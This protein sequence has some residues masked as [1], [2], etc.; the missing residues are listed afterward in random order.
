MRRTGGAGEL[1]SRSKSCSTTV[2]GRQSLAS[3]RWSSRWPAI[4]S[5]AADRSGAR[6]P[7]RA[8]D[9]PSSC[10]LRAGRGTR[11]DRRSSSLSWPLPCRPRYQ[12]SLS[13]TSQRLV[14]ADE[15]VADVVGLDVE[16]RHVAGEPGRQLDVA[17]PATVEE[18]L[19]DAVGGRVE[20]SRDR[21][22]SFEHEG[23][24]GAR[25]GGRSPA[26]GSAPSSGS[27]HRA[28]QSSGSRRPAS[29]D[30]R[31]ATSPKDRRRSTPEPATAPLAAKRVARTATGTRTLRS[32][33]MRA[34]RTVVE[35]DLVGN[36][37][38]GRR[39]ATTTT[40]R[41][42]ADRVPRTAPPRCSAAR[43]AGAVIV[44]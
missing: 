27:I 39:R 13:T 40:D 36:L 18:R 25:C 15:E 31:F 12:P 6:R 2:T 14:P 9:R 4:R 22:R 30:G 24:G 29:I 1:V 19:V 32:D 42:T 8:R 17:D 10:R 23:R 11:A 44:P 3:T 43:R 7:A 16:V 28:D 35:L 26:G 41:A 38:P 37:P 34:S 20:T 5:A 21:R 33:S